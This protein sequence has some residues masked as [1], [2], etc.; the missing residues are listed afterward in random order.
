[1]ASDRLGGFA[2]IFYP[3]SHAV[4]GASV[5]VRKFGGRFLKGS[6]SFGYTGKLCL[7]EG[8]LVYLTL[9]RAARALANLLGYCERSDAVLSS[10]SRK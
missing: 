5:D 3:K 1:M 10:D 7:G 6:L 4:I 2:P 9:E 8:I